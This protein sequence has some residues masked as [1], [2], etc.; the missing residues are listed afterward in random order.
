MT[1]KQIT[2]KVAIHIIQRKRTSEFAF[3]TERKVI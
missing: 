3:Q 1:S 2:L